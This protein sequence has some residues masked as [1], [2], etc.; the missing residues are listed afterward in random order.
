[1]KQATGITPTRDQDYSKWYQ[2]VIK[3]AGLA[4]HSAVRGCMVIKPWGYAL[5]ENIQQYLDK[6]FKKMGHQNAYFPLFIPLSYL[7]K[8]A[9]H[10]EGF[11]KECAVVTHHRLI[12]KEGIL[13]PD[14]KLEEPLIV[15]PTSEMII[16]EMFAK[17]IKSYR[18][19]PLLINQWVNVVRWEMRTRLFLRTAEFLWQE[20][21]TAHTTQQQALEKTKQMLSIYVEFAEKILAIPVIQ[22]KKTET[23]R[24]PGAVT[25]Y[26]LEAMMQDGKALQ[27]G[28]SHFLGQNFSKAQNII[29]QDHQ[30][31]Q[32]FAWTTSW[33]VT[34]RLIGAMIMI[35]GDDDGLILPPR[36]ASAHIA[37]LP[38]FHKKKMDETILSYCKKLQQNLQQIFYHD[39]PLIVHLDDRDM[40]A[41]EKAWDWIKKGV[42]IRIEIGSREIEQKLLSIGIRTNNHKE[43]EKQSEQKLL[44]T[45][46]TQLDAI[47]N[48]L[49]AKAITFR[50]SH[51]QMI[52]S[53]QEFYHFFH[54]DKGFAK[55]HW[56]QDPAVE[57]KI[58]EEL[59]VTIRCIPTDEKKE[60]GRCP[61][62]G[63]PSP[64]RVIFGKSY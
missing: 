41:G 10:V 30:G 31:N 38:V 9:N 45:I 23:E 7:Q 46:T 53:E 18:D 44:E 33:G 42:P 11:A 61:F 55:T 63:K 36:I 22:G 14:G 35:H 2:Q 58:R 1:M 16:G 12:E 24:F 3:M 52:D 57:E 47:Q 39:N 48:I 20:G 17:W 26:C 60:Q 28:T 29:Y 5:W 13:V 50:N 56:S 8:E 51:I 4:E 54:H 21:H 62:T 64:Q 40:R 27:I 25:T 34:T 32:A 49:Y 59:N 37:I 15:R 19:L 6:K 43:F